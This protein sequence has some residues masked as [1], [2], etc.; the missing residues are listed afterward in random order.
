MK[1]IP[2]V[3]LLPYTYLILKYRSYKASIIFLNGLLYH[4]NHTSTKLRTFDT[5]CNFLISL[6]IYYHNINS[7]LTGYF[8][9]FSFIANNIAYKYFSLNEKLS[10]FIH[11]LTVQWPGFYEIYREHLKN[12]SNST[13][14]SMQNLEELRLGY[15]Q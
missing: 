1:L 7:R 15:D 3:G 13:K 5:F 14:S 6:H 8:V 12:S 2:I 11:V 10:Y 4:Y 9:I